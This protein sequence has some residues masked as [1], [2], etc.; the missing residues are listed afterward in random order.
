MTTG[1]REAC[2][3]SYY[4]VQ[5]LYAPIT[6]T[7]PQLEQYLGNRPAERHLHI[8]GKCGNT[9]DATSNTVFRIRRNQ[10]T[11]M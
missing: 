8:N 9:D 5:Y 4:R 7:V 3:P 1:I 6:G 2:T 10:E 11:E